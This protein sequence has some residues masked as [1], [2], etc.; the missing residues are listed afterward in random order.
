MQGVS[1]PG[2][3]NVPT[4]KNQGRVPRITYSSF[5]LQEL[6]EARRLVVFGRGRSDIIHTQQYTKHETI[7]NNIILLV[8]YII[9]SPKAFEYIDKRRRSYERRL[10]FVIFV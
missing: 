2:P 10:I 1:G 4:R 8:I 3:R 7:L 5:I 9:P 6:V